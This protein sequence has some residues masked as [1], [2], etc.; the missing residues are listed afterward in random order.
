LC[1]EVKNSIN[2]P[3]HNVEDKKWTQAVWRTVYLQE[4]HWRPEAEINN[5]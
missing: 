3:T 4:S 1:S 2:K 5:S